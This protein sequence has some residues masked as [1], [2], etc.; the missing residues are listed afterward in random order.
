MYKKIII[1]VIGVLSTLGVFHIINQYFGLK[2]DNV[3]EVAVEEVIKIET[4][5]DIDLT[6]EVKQNEQGIH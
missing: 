1:G 4:G 3:F 6:P 2:D 5:L